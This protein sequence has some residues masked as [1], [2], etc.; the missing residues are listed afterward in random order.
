MDSKKLLE[1][2]NEI[3]KLMAEDEQ[4]KQELVSTPKTLS[5]RTVPHN[6]PS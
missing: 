1:L 3:N 5:T 6:S 4:R 2:V